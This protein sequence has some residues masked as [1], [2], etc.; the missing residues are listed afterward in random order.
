MAIQPHE[1]GSGGKSELCRIAA[2]HPDRP[3]Q[4][5]SVI[6]IAR[7]AKR[8]EELLRMRLEY[9]RSRTHHF[10]PNAS[11]ITRRAHLIQSAMG[12]RQVFRLRQCSLTGGLSGPVHV[13]H[14]PLSACS[15]K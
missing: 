3:P 14:R 1:Q 12:R 11:L 6:P 2:D 13:D 7:S 10:P 4:F 5:S 9:D 8:A 15:V